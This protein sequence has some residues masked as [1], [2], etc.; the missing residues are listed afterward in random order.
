MYVGRMDEKYD[1]IMKM[2]NS[3]YLYRNDR[4]KK[5]SLKKQVFFLL[6]VGPMDSLTM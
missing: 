4:N 3:D 2:F 1:V 6:T 5:Y